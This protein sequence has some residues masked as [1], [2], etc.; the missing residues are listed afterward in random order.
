MKQWIL[1]LQVFCGLTLPGMPSLPGAPGG[2]DQ[3]RDIDLGVAVPKAVAIE[4]LDQS[5]VDS[6]VKQIEKAANE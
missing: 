2:F 3:S 6:C 4:N 5:Q 1:V